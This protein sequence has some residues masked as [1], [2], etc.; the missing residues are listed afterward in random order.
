MSR[1]LWCVMNG[2]ALAPPG[3]FNLTYNYGGIDNA[4]AAIKKLVCN[5]NIASGNIEAQINIVYG[6]EGV[7]LINEIS[8]R[9]NLNKTMV[10]DKFVKNNVTKNQLEAA[11]LTNDLKKGYNIFNFG[12]G[13]DFSN[14]GNALD[15]IKQL[16]DNSVLAA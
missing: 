2:R 7:N 5:A 8:K 14:L 10:Y 3:A 4:I 15:E 16:I 1:V 12:W 9:Y 6:Q 11:G 13:A